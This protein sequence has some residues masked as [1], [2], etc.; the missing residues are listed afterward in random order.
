MRKHNGGSIDH[1]LLH[2]KVAIEVWS[3]VLQL[4]DV[5]WVMLGRMKDCLGS[6]RGQ[7]G[8]CTVLQIW[9]IVHL[10]IMWCLLRE[11]NAWSFEDRE[12]ESSS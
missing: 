12:L 11:R 8:N 2:C 6:W 4:F 5:T 1:L 9:R 7:R 10:C 3:M